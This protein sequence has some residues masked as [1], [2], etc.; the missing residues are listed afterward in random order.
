M[1]KTLLT[2]FFSF[3]LLPIFPQTSHEGILNTISYLFTIKEGL[4]SSKITCIAQE[5]D[6]FF[7]IGTEDGLNRFDGYDFTIYKKQYAD[8]LSLIS[9]HITAL[10]QDSR[11]RMWIATVAGLEYY[12][13]SVDGFINV[14]LNQPDRVVKQNQCVA[15]MED[16]K[17]QVW[18]ASSGVGVLRYSPD[19]GESFLFTPS[20]DGSSSS[21]CSAYILSI[22]EDQQ[23]NLWFGSQDKGISVYNPATE[24]FQHY[25]TSN[26]GLPGDAVPDLRLLRDGNMLVAT[27][28]GGVA[29]YDTNKQLFMT[30]PDVFNPPYTRSIFCVEE[31]ERG[32]ILIGTEGNGVF[33]FDPGARELRRYPILEEFS[34]EFNDAKISSL[35]IGRH[36]YVWIG[37]KYKGVFVAG[38]EHSGFR[39]IR[40]INNNLNSLNYNYVTGITTDKDRDMWIATDG[41]GLNRYRL[42]TRRFTCY[43]YRQDDPL[44]LRDNVVLSVLCDSRNRIWVGTYQGGLCLFDR[45]TENFIHF[46]TNEGISG[47]L[48]SDYI[49]S[50]QEDKE[51][52][53]WLGT[54]GGGLTRFDPENHTFRTF[55]KHAGKGLADDYINILFADSKNRLWIGTNSGLSLLDIDTETFSVYGKE[56]GLSNLSVYSIGESPEGTIWVGTA[57]G[58]NRYDP[59]R[60][61]FSWVFPASPRETAVINGIVPDDDRLWLSTNRGIVAY[62]IRNAD[63]RVYSQ[64][65][66]G[67]GSDEFLQ[68]SYYKSP[69]GEIFFGGITGLS[70]FY[71]SEIQDSVTLQKVYIT[72]LSISNEPVLINKEINGRL[73]L[74][75]NINESKKIKLRYSDKNF[76]LDFVAMGS[77]KPYSTVY[78]CKLEGFDT[79][80]VIYDYAHRSVTYTNLNPGTY[81]FR[82][83]AS[84]DP[85]IW[86]D[87]DTSL[88]IE[89]EP[90]LWRTWWAESLY[91][92]LSLGIIYAV[93]RFTI[94]RI[95][96]KNELHIERIKVKQQEELN[97]VR[98]NFFTNISHEFRTPLTLIIGPLK[99]LISE[100]GSEERKKTGLLILRNAER[101]QHLINQ[102]LDLNKIEE[103][104]MRLHVQELE[105]VSFVSNCVNIFTELM[106]QKQISLTY[107]WNPDKIEA[108]YDPDMLDKCLNNLLYN[109][110]K[111]TPH[112][113]KIHVEVRKN[114][115]GKILLTISD[116]GIGMN[117]ETLTH[118][119]DRFFQGDTHQNYT[120]TGIGMHLTK[121]II[122]LHK[123]SISVQSEEGRGSAFFLTI[124]PGKAHFKAEELRKK[125]E[126]SSS[127]TEEEAYMKELRELTSRPPEREGD[128]EPARLLL[129][130]DNYDMRFYIRQELSASYLIEEAVDGKTGLDKAR[131]LMPDLII[132]D[133]MMPEMSGTELCRILKSDPETCHIPI[134]I[135]TAQD[136]MNHRLEGVESG[137]DSF[138][139]KPF[140]TKYLQVRIEKLIEIRRRMK[141]RFSKS[142][143]MDAQEVTLTSM[144]ERLLQKVIDYVRANIENPEL[145]VEQ[146]SRELGMSRTHLH[147]KLK[148]LT[149]KSPVEFI[150]M[151]RMKQAAYL[152]T[153]GKLSV[154]EVGYK[155]GYNTP[156]YFSSSFNAYF[157]MSPTAYMEKALIQ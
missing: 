1:K 120:G 39:T 9:N 85:Q 62:S 38:N 42:A 141:E 83:K 121:T 75:R 20:P 98:T 112:G 117:Q 126:Q 67:I 61:Q 54:Y 51:G 101:L 25:H 13:P 44:S 109:A 16:R 56:S 10:F 100:D 66:S 103:G 107:V 94:I 113:G 122:E 144:D 143:Y 41:G 15:I 155:V 130:E 53:L 147:R 36:N 34:A 64:S 69:D 135:L 97:Q 151:I 23:G 88:I 19:T 29:I 86:G 138:I 45:Q 150:K 55:R 50:L 60:N 80:W 123:G 154:S 96:E 26:S 35:Y 4:S 63:I 46:N 90:P 28:K 72:H 105:L 84:S 71:P 146:M 157:G 8:S 87:E 148:A 115:D 52:I 18:F 17:G 93:F 33:E 82:V 116:T 104:K 89:I 21:L 14:S 91:V 99:R 114:E 92:L 6:G 12:E 77:Y 59:G 27:L 108:W 129:I 137:A 11:Q 40:K 43:T 74:T 78:A 58:L 110:F 37:L 47:E 73:V 3:L 79:D 119:F 149:G 132:T 118:L 68:G 131:R 133:I 102:I 81:T 95:R 125:E 70:S 153:T 7:W 49:K 152:L 24:T 156:S 134:I 22:A 139:T 106:R 145:S 76:T 128:T 30:Y 2:L 5:D 140:S 65:N 142:I 31:D 57:N 136:D 32:K 124:L 48:Q 111:F 127:S